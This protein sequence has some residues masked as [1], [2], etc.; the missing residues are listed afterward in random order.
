[1]RAFLFV[2]VCLLTA[3]V[4]LQGQ[5]AE[6]DTITGPSVPKI[7]ILRTIDQIRIDG[8]IDEA[9]WERAVPA[10]NFWQHFPYDSLLALHQTEIGMA[11]DDQFLYVYTKCYADS[12]GYIIPSLRRDYN[13]SGNDNI[14]ILFDTYNDQTNAFLFGMN[15]YGVRREALIS[16]GGTQRG[17]FADSWDNKWFGESKIYDKYWIAEFAIPFKTIRFNEGSKKWRF[18]SYR[19]DAQ[20]N[21]ISTWIHIPKNQI[22]MDLGR[23]GEL[24]WEDPL[25]KAGANISLIP[26]ATSSLFRDF[27]DPN[28]EGTEFDLDIGGDV[29][30]A[31]TSGLNL[32]LTANPDFSQVEV[33][34][35]VTNLDRF[36]IFFPEKRQFF[37][38]NA[39]LFGSFGLRRVNPFFS[40]RIGV[41]VDTA[42]GQ[43]VQNNILLGARLSGK[44]NDDLRVGI[45][46]MQTARQRENGLPGFNYT[47]AALQQKV[48]TRSNISAILVNKQ[49]FNAENYNGGFLDYNRVLGL[50]Y[51]LATPQN[52][53]SGK[54]FYHQVFS[55]LDQ[56]HKFTHGAQLEYLQRRYRLEWA[57]LFVGQGFDA[58]VGF[59]PRRDYFFLS[60]EAELF[61]YPTGGNLNE[62]KVSV[63][64]RLF[65]QVG[66]DGND[67][68]DPWSLSEKQV[69]V[70]WDFEY[71][72]SADFSLEYTFTDIFLLRDFDPTRVQEE[73][74]FLPAGSTYSFSSVQARYQSDQRKTFSYELSP[75]IG[76]FY[77]GFRT[78]LSGS[79]TYRYQPFGFA[80]L[81]YELNYISL[82][83]PFENATLWLFGPRIDLTF[84]KKVFLTTFI[85]YNSQ[86][87]NLNINTRFQWRYAPVSD[88]FLVYTDNYLIDPFS[89]FSKRNR[90]LVAKVTYWLNP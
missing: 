43:N 48:F 61:F 75:T 56:P 84:S 55:P 37:L 90:G 1:M 24:N 67:L 59:V 42:T 9:T 57:H 15:P 17:D 27:E 78:G 44:V 86:F 87:D 49:A 36:E 63:D 32:D 73:D 76:Q 3:S 51:R 89:Q 19:F 53:W 85:Q 29:K 47:V 12:T 16:N 69:E 18:N 60:P 64:T 34:Q 58:E 8:I 28:Q 22:I 50:E 35:Q 5:E 88:F 77:N 79:F 4:S 81:D 46:S 25:Q 33:D 80:S 14:S 40:R 82:D 41:A 71:N 68:L 66:K 6:S 54:A 65:F 83:K 2:L 72:S 20:V 38:E 23:T 70:R 10:R 39:D 7:Q 30:I 21:E 74:I 26:Y 11:Y 52:K 13:F 45:M 62:H 31:V